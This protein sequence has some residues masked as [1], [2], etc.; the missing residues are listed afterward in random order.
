MRRTADGLVVRKSTKYLCIHHKSASIRRKNAIL[1]PTRLVEP[2]DQ[3]LLLAALAFPTRT[4]P[5]VA[6]EAADMVLVSSDV[7]DVV[8]ALH[9][10]RKAS[11][12]V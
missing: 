7:C 5:Q 11:R 9:L 10:G 6:M 3:S 1:S 12:E 8:S 4:A 2:K